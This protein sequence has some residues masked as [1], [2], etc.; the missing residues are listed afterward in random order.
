M[1][2]VL[3]ILD[4][5]AFLAED[6]LAMTLVIIEEEMIF[7]QGSVYSLCAWPKKNKNE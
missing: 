7:V 6:A 1:A 2:S 4:F 3:V 5:L